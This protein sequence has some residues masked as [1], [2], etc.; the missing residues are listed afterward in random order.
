L[1]EANSLVNGN[2][3]AYEI[4]NYLTKNEKAIF[5]EWR[6]QLRDT[7]ARIALTGESTGLNRATSAITASAGMEY[8]SCVS[9]SGQDTCRMNYEFCPVSHTLDR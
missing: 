6:R 9:M 7:K 3:A 4:R 1:L 2:D 8:G 5:M